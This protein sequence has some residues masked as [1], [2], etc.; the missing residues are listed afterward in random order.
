HQPRRDWQM[1]L[2]ALGEPSTAPWFELFVRQLLA[3]SPAVLPLLARNPFPDRPPRYIRPVVY[4]YRFAPPADHRRGVWW[5]RELIG[6][7]MPVLSAQ[8]D[9]GTAPGRA[10]SASGSRWTSRSRRRCA[11]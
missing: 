11:R 7:Y 1:S 10:S 4:R 5:T 9:A 6:D 2:A 3:R 8:T